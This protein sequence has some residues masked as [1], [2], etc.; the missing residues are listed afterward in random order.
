M[1]RHIFVILCLA[2]L[3]FVRTAR[4]DEATMTIAKEHYE[5]GQKLFALQRFEAALVEYQLAFDA[6]QMPDLLF[7]IGQCQRNLGND[8]EAIFAFERYLQLVPT[9]PNREAVER[10]VTKLKERQ[11]IIEAAKLNIRTSGSDLG[12]V[13]V[14][15]DRPARPSPPEP[16]PLYKKWWFWTGAAL[17]GATG[18]ITIYSLTRPLTGPPSTDLGHIAYPR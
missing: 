13:I 11:A 16:T 17:V 18:G 2:S 9:A 6:E 10:L 5:E 14:F 8:D 12:P 3:A 15:R 1:R 7:N 4:A